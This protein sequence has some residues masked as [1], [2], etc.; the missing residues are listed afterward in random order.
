MKE[1]ESRVPFRVRFEMD[2]QNGEKRVLEE[3]A[4]LQEAG[5]VRLGSRSERRRPPYRRLAG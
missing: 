4:T 2:G 5:R 3:T 1:G